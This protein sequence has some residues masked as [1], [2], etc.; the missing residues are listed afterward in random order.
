MKSLN[1]TV[2]TRK[3]LGK[4]GVERSLR[5]VL[6]SIFDYTLLQPGKNKDP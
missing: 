5:P 3:T 6:R 1:N 4:Y 2:Q